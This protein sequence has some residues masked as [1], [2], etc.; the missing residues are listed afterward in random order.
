MSAKYSALLEACDKVQLTGKLGIL[1]ESSLDEATSIKMKLVLNENINFIKQQL[2]RTP[3]VENIQ[4]NLGA[5]WTQA[6]LEDIDVDGD[7]QT[8]FMKNISGI[9]DGIVGGFKTIGEKL[10]PVGNGYNGA[11]EVAG[12]K[13]ALAK[14]LSAISGDVKD[15]GTRIA[16]AGSGL[17]NKTADVSNTIKGYMPVSGEKYSAMEH[18]QQALA[19]DHAALQ[20]NYNSL[21]NEHSAL[22]GNYNSMQGSQQALANDYAALAQQTNGYGAQAGMA[23]DKSLAANPIATNTALGSAAGLAGYG[24]YKLGQK[25]FRRR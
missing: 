18:S 12:G 14:N 9:K 20:G 5:R 17:V 7:T 6:I 2:F 13:T 22:Q 10:A 25:V 16:D 3:L 8:A 11:E 23:L 4:A 1:E 15:L 21:Q 24:A 19:N